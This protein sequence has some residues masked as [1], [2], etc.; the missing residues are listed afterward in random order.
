MRFPLE[1]TLAEDLKRSSRHPPTV[2]A[3]DDCGKADR[4]RYGSV[5]IPRTFPEPRGGSNQAEIKLRNN[6]RGASAYSSRS[7]LA[8]RSRETCS[9][10]TSRGQIGRLR[11]VQCNAHSKQ[12]DDG[13]CSATATTGCS[14]SQARAGWL[15]KGRSQGP[16]LPRASRASADQSSRLW[17]LSRHLRETF[18]MPPFA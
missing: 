8:R 1:T 14:S 7:S 16:Q 15:L 9:K 2:K 12:S 3:G 11:R 6:G 5:N 13:R 10:T 18:A 4:P 17:M